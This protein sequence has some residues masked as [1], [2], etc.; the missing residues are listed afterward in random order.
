MESGDDPTFSIDESGDDLRAAKIN[1]KEEVP[2][3][4]LFLGD[5]QLS[6]MTDLRLVCMLSAA[7]SSTDALTLTFYPRARGVVKRRTLSVSKTGILGSRG[8]HLLYHLPSI[9]D[10]CGGPGA[11]NS[12]PRLADAGEMRMGQRTGQAGRDAG[13]RQ[14]CD[15][16]M[17]V[18]KRE[19]VLYNGDVCYTVTNM[20]SSIPG[21][22][23]FSVRPDWLGFSR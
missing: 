2:G 20:K 6:R 9:H 7:R 14:P 8:P 12:A 18:D 21:G 15:P 1:S 10:T 4:W 22:S 13:R 3:P 16:G 11:G 23:R 19:Q 17:Q 5:V